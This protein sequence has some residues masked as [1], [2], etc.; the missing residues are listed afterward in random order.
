MWGLPSHLLRL[1]DGRLLMTYGHR[2]PPLGN[3][4]RLSTDEGRTWSDPILV[5]TDGHSGDLG[6]PS[7]A[8]LADG[9]LL[10]VWYE[11]MKDN[12]RA[13]LRQATWRPNPAP[14]GK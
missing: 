7:T 2:R 11:Q 9:T 6:Y 4:A 10:T 1:R 13:V 3:Q 12:P 14:T 5:S 8:E